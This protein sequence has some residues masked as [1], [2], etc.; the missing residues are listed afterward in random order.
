MQIIQELNFLKNVLYWFNEPN[1]KCKVESLKRAIVRVIKFEW[2]RLCCQNHSKWLM[3]IYRTP[4][5]V[6]LLNFSK[7][8]NKV[9]SSMC[10][11]YWTSISRSRRIV[12]GVSGREK[13]FFASK[14]LVM[15]V[16]VIYNMKVTASVR[17]WSDVADLLVKFAR[18]D[19]QIVSCWLWCKIE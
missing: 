19:C 15:I 4:K 5:C 13:L 18:R 12:P 2:R 16:I 11:R 17:N 1:K 8:I 10:I 7:P 3:I 6:K 9:R 14:H